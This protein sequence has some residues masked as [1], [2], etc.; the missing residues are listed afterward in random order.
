[1]SI[2]ERI[3]TWFINLFTYE[4]EDKTDNTESTD[5]EAVNSR[6][7]NSSASRNNKNKT[8]DN[9][10]KTKRKLRT[11]TIILSEFWNFL[12]RLSRGIF[13]CAVIGLILNVIAAYFYPELPERIP[14][15]FGWYDGCMQF[16]EFAFKAAFGYINA[17]FHGVDEAY[18]FLGEFSNEYHELWLQ[19]VSWLNTIHF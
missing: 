2:I 11:S 9:T 4:V 14:T 13:R 7:N 17:F 12:N 19:F 16:L 6:S 15:L 18:K 10:K 1:M 5:V 8:T 3:R